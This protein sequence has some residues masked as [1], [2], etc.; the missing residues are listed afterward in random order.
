LRSPRAPQSLITLANRQLA[1]DIQ[2]RWNGEAAVPV[3]HAELQA[4]VV[5]PGKPLMGLWR[6]IFRHRTANPEDERL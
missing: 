6:S 5:R 1:G 2:L 4:P 3:V